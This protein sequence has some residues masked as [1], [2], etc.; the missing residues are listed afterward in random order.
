[1][2]EPEKINELLHLYYEGATS[3]EQ[4]QEFYRC[5]KKDGD[6][7]ESLRSEAELFLK[8]FSQS[9]AEDN[10]I[11]IPKG[12]DERLNALL[13]RFAA[14]EKKRKR[15][16]LWKQAGGIAASVAILLSAGILFKQNMHS[17]L[18][19]T[20]STPEEAY[21]ETQH[22]LMLV[23]ERLN[24]GFSRLEKADGNIMK[25]NEILNKKRN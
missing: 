16:L 20:Y 24:E 23:S 1:M 22:A 2:I 25:V 12:F 8:L 9:Y 21:A 19:D 14:K 15:I 7:P 4:E 17:G 3:P 13:D 10:S 5:L 11:D 18:T 6:I